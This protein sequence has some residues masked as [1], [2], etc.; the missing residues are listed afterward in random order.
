MGKHKHAVS[1]VRLE[2]EH[3]S[4]W[5]PP[6]QASLGRRLGSICSSKKQQQQGKQ[7]LNDVSGHALPG[8]MMAI[9]G[10]SGAGK[11]TLLG[12]L[13]GGYMGGDVWGCAIPL[14]VRPST[15]HNSA[16]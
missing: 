7:L 10:P 12:V 9:M 2:F 5:L 16:G 14:C 1:H 6:E 3:V 8:R 11:T 13:S 15:L 4:L